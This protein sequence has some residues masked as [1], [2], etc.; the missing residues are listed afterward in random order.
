M[1]VDLMVRKM[2]SFKP[3]DGYQPGELFMRIESEMYLKSTKMGSHII[4]KTTLTQLPGCMKAEE[5]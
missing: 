5:M 3:I 1:W 4:Q 2:G